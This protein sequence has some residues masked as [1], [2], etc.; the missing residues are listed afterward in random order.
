MGGSSGPAERVALFRRGEN[1]GIGGEVGIGQCEVVV[2]TFKLW[3]RG[4]QGLRKLASAL[5]VIEDFTLFEK[6]QS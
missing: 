4:Y 6:E 3:L 1:I 2:E 5:H